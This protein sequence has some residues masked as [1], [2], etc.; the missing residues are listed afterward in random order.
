MTEQPYNLGRAAAMA[1]AV[2]LAAAVPL[3][4]AWTLG[5]HRQ[6]AAL[7]GGELAREA[8]PGSTLASDLEQ[9]LKRLERTI[10]FDWIG[11]GAAAAGAALLALALQNGKRGTRNPERG[12][13]SEATSRDGAASF[14][15]QVPS[16]P[17]FAPSSGFR[18]PRFPFWVAAAAAP[19]ACAVLCAAPEA[20]S[21]ESVPVARLVATLLA[22]V[23]WLVVAR[24]LPGRLQY[25]VCGACLA[26]A[27][28]FFTWWEPPPPKAVPL[29]RPL[30][31]LEKELMAKLPGW[32]GAARRMPKAI[33]GQVGADEYLNLDLTPP[34]GGA[35]VT[36]YIT[37]NANA[38]SQIPHVPWVCMTQAGYQLVEIRQD[39]VAIAGVAGRE[40]QPNVILFEGGSGRERARA[41]MFQYFRV[42]ETY[43]WSRQLARFLATT[44]SLGGAGSFLS[45]TQVAVWLA[46]DDTR[47]PLDKNSPAYRLGLQVL[48]LLV[49][50]LERGYYPDLKRPGG[51]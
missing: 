21:Q 24:P 34:A 30:A 44:G 16:S 12:T 19:A 37:Y 20:V 29:A 48:E 32:T 11:V 50:L 23:A 8:Q 1:A 31:L 14:G 4:T 49:P 39:G 2:L 25:G 35:R 5:L 42:G 38:M 45:Q 36:V 46:P 9:Q 47:D 10:V 40:I 28:L 51:G 18:V 13:D 3:G 6:Q 17:L 22:T 26:V 41:L 33:E 15:V 43:T 27:A 7:A